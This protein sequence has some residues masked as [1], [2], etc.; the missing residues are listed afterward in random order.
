LVAAG[1]HIGHSGSHFGHSGAH[2]G[3][4]GAHLGRSGAH[5]GHS[6][7]H[8]GRSGT[9]IGHS[10]T[11]IGH[12]GTHI[13][14]SGAH[15]GHSGGQAHS[16][17]RASPGVSS[18]RHPGSWN[19]NWALHHGSLG[20]HSRAAHD[21]HRGAL[22]HGHAKGHV[23][24]RFHHFYYPWYWSYFRWPG[25]YGY[26]GHGYPYY[27]DRYRYPY[28]GD[29]VYDEGSSG[30]APY[31]AAA[32]SGGLMTAVAP[33]ARTDAS[34][35]Y[36][37]AR[38][39]FQEGDFRNAMRLAAHAAIDDPE[40]ANVHVLLGLAMFAQG[41]FLATLKT[42]PDDRLAAELLTHVGGRAPADIARRQSKAPSQPPVEPQE[43]PPAKPPAKPAPPK[44][45]PEPATPPA[46]VR[47]Y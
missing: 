47:R 34:E 24:H 37:R 7:T 28:D 2:I 20:S 42:A 44:S 4:S 41:E 8:I 36:D 15:I 18:H 25:Y 5:I 38:T 13:G 39:A 29:Y 14:R 27:S 43:K 45:S 9:H 23:G 32:P 22:H 19:R 46:P 1:G 26:Y 6:G 31:T 35:F 30:I 11:H 3:H 12:S 16:G 21:L 40:D 33:E 17:V 10:G